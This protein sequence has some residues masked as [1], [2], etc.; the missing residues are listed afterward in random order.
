MAELEWKEIEWRLLIDRSFFFPLTYFSLVTFPRILPQ[1]FR[2][3]RVT[4]AQVICLHSFY[5]FQVMTHFVA[6]ESFLNKYLTTLCEYI[7]LDLNI[8][9]FFFCRVLL[10]INSKRDIKFQTFYITNYGNCF[11]KKQCK[12]NSYKIKRTL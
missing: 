11:T 12:K 6:E 8:V 5:T 1:I 7:S 2:S 9:A 3:D 4:Y 10:T